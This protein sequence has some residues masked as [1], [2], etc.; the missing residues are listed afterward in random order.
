MSQFNISEGNALSKYNSQMEDARDKF[1]VEMRQVID[2]SNVQW[3]RSINTA[4]NA[5]QNRVNQLNVQNLLDM[6]TQSQNNLWNRYRD[7]ASWLMQLRESREAR[8]H[9]AALQSQQNNFSM[10][11]YED[12]VKNNF[13]MGLGSAVISGVFGKTTTGGKP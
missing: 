2:Q 13:W 12:E 6:T 1:N 11:M 5:E 9:Q 3:R 10:S 4:N 8:A 7:E